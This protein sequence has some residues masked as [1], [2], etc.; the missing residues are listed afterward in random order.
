MNCPK[1][2]TEMIRGRKGWVCE[3]C[4][5][6][7]SGESDSESVGA[8][9]TGGSDSGARDPRSEVSLGERVTIQ[10]AGATGSK[11]A[12]PAGPKD[13]PL[14]Q[15]YELGEPWVVDIGSMLLKI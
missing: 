6:R 11:R 5:T 8:R 12:G 10:G 2:S 4:G 14:E 1:F 3:E 9:V 7:H 13:A 15:R